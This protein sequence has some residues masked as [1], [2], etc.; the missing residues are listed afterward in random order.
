MFADDCILFGEVSDRE[1]MVLKDILREYKSCWQCVNFE[2]S[3]A[4]SS[5]NVTDH[6]KI[7]A[8]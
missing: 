6:D 8:F 2:K 3:T 1:I 4:F 7:L 5:S